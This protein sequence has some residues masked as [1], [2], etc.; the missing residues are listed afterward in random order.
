MSRFEEHEKEISE[1]YKLLF[2]DKDKEIA[3]LKEEI[4]KHQNVENANGELISLNSKLEER[5]KEILVKN[6]QI[7]QLEVYIYTIVIPFIYRKKYQN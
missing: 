5:N 2:V 4:L 1:S 6:N 7:H 3:E